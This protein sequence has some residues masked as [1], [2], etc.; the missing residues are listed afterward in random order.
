MKMNYVD[1][2]LTNYEIACHY[3]GKDRR[4]VVKKV[5]WCQERGYLITIKTEDGYRSLWEKKMSDGFNVIL[6]GFNT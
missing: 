4:G 2:I 5:G 6:P 1:S 3:N